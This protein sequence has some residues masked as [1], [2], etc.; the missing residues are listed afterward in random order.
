MGPTGGKWIILMANGLC[1]CKMNSIDKKMNSIG[2][3]ELYW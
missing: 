1:W 3:N 2:G